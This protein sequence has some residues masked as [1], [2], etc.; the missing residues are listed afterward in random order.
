MNIRSENCTEAFCGKKRCKKTEKVCLCL[1]KQRTQNK[2]NSSRA[3]FERKRKKNVAQT[4]DIVTV[5][6]SKWSIQTSVAKE[7]F[8]IFTVQKDHL[9]AMSTNID[10]QV[11]SRKLLVIFSFSLTYAFCFSMY[12]NICIFFSV[13]INFCCSPSIASFS[14]K[15]FDSFQVLHV[16]FYIKKDLQTQ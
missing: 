10:D 13:H 16:Q 7:F 1:Q 6:S 2:T 15:H 9:C 11:Q 5:M 4:N 3:S 14:G 12:F 8:V